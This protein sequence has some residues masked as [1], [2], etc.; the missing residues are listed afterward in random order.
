MKGV[1]WYELHFIGALRPNSLLS[2]FSVVPVFLDRC[3]CQ[4]K[5]S[6]GSS[7]IHPPLFNKDVDYLRPPGTRRHGAEDIESGARCNLIVWNYNKAYRQSDQYRASRLP[8][9]YRKESGEP[10]PICLSETHDILYVCVVVKN[11]GMHKILLS[12]IGS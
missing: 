6:E 3:N 2:P 1:T 11:D 9:R 10:D 5:I 12:R 7:K 4:R 8:H